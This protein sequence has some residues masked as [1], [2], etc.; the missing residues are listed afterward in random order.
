ME[1]DISS[2]AINLVVTVLVY[3]FY[4]IIQRFILNKTYEEKQAKKLATINTIVVYILL[5]VYLIGFT[6]QNRIANPAPALLYGYIAYLIL[7]KKHEEKIGQEED[8]DLKNLIENLSKDKS[9][10]A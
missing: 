10:N 3:E 4:P 9:T 7:K 8:E 5:T 1:I 2:I 6:D